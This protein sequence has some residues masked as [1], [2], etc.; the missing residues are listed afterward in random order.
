MFSGGTGKTCAALGIS[1]ELSR[2][3]DKKVIYIRFEEMPATEL[4]IGNHPQ[5][6]NIGDY[7]YYLFE[8]NNLSL[9]SRPA[10]FTSADHYGVETFYP[11]KGR[12]DLSYLTQQELIHF[13]KILS[14]SCRYDYI[15]LDLKSDLSE[16]TLFLAN[17]CGKIILL[18]NDDPV[19]ELKT[20]KLISY[21]AQKDFD[22]LKERVILAVNRSLGSEHDNRDYGDV[23]YSQIKKIYIEKDE[24]S[25]HSSSGHMDID[26][27]HAF[28]VGIKKITDE[29][30]L[31]TKKEE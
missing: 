24:N 11:T 8:K 4:F 25:F 30:L 5:N 10:G 23:F 31:Q 18:Q 17:L 1:R 27:N 21:L 7:L 26:I 29:L 3:N 2:F 15:T 14:D 9:C 16:D 22:G 28:G 6:R 19:S 12:N 20:R 13:L